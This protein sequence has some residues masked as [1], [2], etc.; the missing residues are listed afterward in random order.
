MKARME[1]WKKLIDGAET[2]KDISKVLMD[3]ISECQSNSMMYENNILENQ[4]KIRKTIGDNKE[5]IKEVVATI[6][7]LNQEIKWLAD[8]LLKMEDMMVMMDDKWT[9]MAKGLVDKIEK[10][11]D[12]YERRRV[13]KN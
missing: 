4:I 13:H 10:E 8:K 6:S 2:P 11:R 12:T 5:Y 7:K 3:Y 1:K 9:E